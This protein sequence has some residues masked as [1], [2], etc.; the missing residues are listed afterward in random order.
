MLRA[1]WPCA[2]L[3]SLLLGGGVAACQGCGTAVPGANSGDASAAQP[4]VRLYLVSTLAGAMEPCGCTKD[5]LGG[6]D[7][8]AALVARDRGQ[9][10][11]S[12]VIG[13]GPLLF[14]DPELGGDR[15]TQTAW[16]A[17]ALAAAL[18]QIGLAG[19]APGYNDWAAGADALGKATAAAGAQLFASNLDGAPLS[20]QGTK[21][22][23]REVAG[24]K[25]G[26]VGVSD[27]KNRAGGL[28]PGVTARPALEAMRAGVADAKQQGAQVIIG[29]A[30]LPRGEALRIADEVGDLSVLLVGKPYEAGD[31]NDAPKSPQMV[32]KTLVVET[33][34]HLQTVGVVD[35]VVAPASAGEARVVFADAGGVARGEELVALSKRIRDLEARINGWENDKNV[36]AEDVA[37]RKADLAKMRA[38]KAELE[39]P[40]APPP[41]SYFR[42]S[43]VEVRAELGVEDGVAKAMLAYYKRVNDHNK[44]AFADRKP[45]PPEKGKAGYVGNDECATCHEDAKKVWD[46]TPHAHAYATLEKEFKEFNLDCVSCHVTGYGKPGGS[47]VTFVESLKNVGCEECHGPGSLH[48]A[49][50]LAK[51]IIKD[52]DPQACVSAC[53]HPPHVE[54]FDPVAKMKLVLGPGHGLPLGGEPGGAASGAPS[55]KPAAPSGSPAAS[56][57]GKPR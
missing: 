13:A 44:T 31:I 16:K 33:A 4:T 45:P 15:A 39:K 20:G 19:W 50:Q 47:T 54:G 3:L 18:K 12:L 17:D 38:D 32:D 48:A 29:V 49:S 56:A 6:V 22:T 23:M 2:L 40:Q 46:G 25:V 53:H 9:A 52:P 36:K 37:A 30:A 35:L 55:A 14:M 1:G 10:K 27:P 43:M 8:L 5:Q 26:I 34:N 21:A 7:H 57:S 11:G 28:P 42:Y 51:D 24:V 41:G